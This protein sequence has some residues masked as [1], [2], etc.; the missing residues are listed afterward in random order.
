MRLT[1][2][3]PT[4]NSCSMCPPGPRSLSAKLLSSQLISSMC[5]CRGLFHAQYRTSR[6]PLLSLVRL[7][8]TYSSSL[9]WSLL[10]TALPS[11]ISTAPLQAGIIHKFADSALSPI[12]QIINSEDT[13][14][15]W[16]QNLPL[17]GIATSNQLSDGLSTANH[18]LFSL[19]VQPVSHPPYHLLIL[20]ISHYFDW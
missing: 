14:P 2:F 15:H 5:K 3:A 17:R 10:I 6:L 1:L 7:L 9:S 19:V 12:V 13:K 8:A 11:S 20:S 16:P 18:N 4:A